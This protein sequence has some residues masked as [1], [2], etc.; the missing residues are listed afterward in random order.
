MDGMIDRG[1]TETFRAS[2]LGAD[3]LSDGWAPQRS[4]KNAISCVGISL[5]SG[6]RTH[7]TLRPAATGTGIVFRR[8]DLEGIEIAACFENV[9]DSRLCTVIARTDR[10][11]ARVGTIEHVMAALAGCGIDNAVVEVDGPEVP[12]LDGS[13]APLVFLIE[14]AGVA[15]QDAPRAAIEILRP[16]RVEEGAAFAELRPAPAAGLAM[17]FSIAFDVPAIGSQARSL[18]LTPEAFRRDLARARTF[19]LAAEVAGLHAAGL[20]LGGS[21]DNA[22]V[23]DH[24]R[25]LNPG[26]LRMPDEFVRHKMLDAIGDLAL[27]AAPLRGRFIGHRSGHALNTRLL[28]TLFATPSAWQRVVPS[29][30]LSAAA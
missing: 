1:M 8:T 3:L 18:E 10:P 24:E 17:T 22:V 5:H 11:E 30:W 14:C 9:V 27:A 26:G 4:L 20:A 21:M 16:V 2:Q 13:A 15:E 28:R 25:V 7:M 23:V 29:P 19:T 6:R 12:I